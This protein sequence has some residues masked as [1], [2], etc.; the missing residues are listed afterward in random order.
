L[1]EKARD[2]V[3]AEAPRLPKYVCVETID[4]SYFSRREPPED[5]P[6]CERIAVDRKKGRYHLKLDATDRLRVS[7]AIAEGRPGC[8]VSS[9]ART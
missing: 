8:S 1:L 2:K 6:S 7:V 3:L 5:A 4:R 9:R